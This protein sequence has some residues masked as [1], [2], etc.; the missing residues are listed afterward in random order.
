MYLQNLTYSLK[1]KGIA[2]FITKAAEIEREQLVQGGFIDCGPWEPIT[3]KTTVF[4]LH[5]ALASEESS[6]LLV[7]AELK[8]SSATFDAATLGLSYLREPGSPKLSVISFTEAQPTATESIVPETAATESA[9]ETETVSEGDAEISTSS[10]RFEELLPSP[11]P[12]S[13][14][15]ASLA[16][17]ISI[18]AADNLEDWRL[19]FRTPE[20]HLGNPLF[21]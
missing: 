11:P 3:N 4:S 8:R 18:Q 7:A 6:E 19:H 14:L 5:P 21:A 20:V 1:R 15:C 10:Y 16:N 12:Q 9:E 13:W 2:K 17:L